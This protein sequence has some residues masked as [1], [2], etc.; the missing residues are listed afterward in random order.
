MVAM[1]YFTTLSNYDFKSD[2][3]SGWAEWALAHPNFGIS[4]NPIPML[5]G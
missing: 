2:A 5:W 4:V 3:V 1:K